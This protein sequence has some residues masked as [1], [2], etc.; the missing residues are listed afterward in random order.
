MDP[1][2]TI[3]RVHQCSKCPGDTSYKCESCHCDLCPQCK[4]SHEKDLKTIDH[5]VST[6]KEYINMRIQTV[7]IAKRQQHIRTIH[8]IKSEA[9][10][11]RPVLLSEIKSD[12]NTFQKKIPHGQSD[13]LSKA[14][15]LNHL[16]DNVLYDLLDNA[17]CD[18]NFKHR[19]LK[20]EIK[21]YKHISQLQ[22]YV[23]IYEQWAI[24]PLQFLSFIKK[25]LPQI[26]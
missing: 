25:A 17:F 3:C 14:R 9:L 23:H 24:R 22:N 10:F 26:T 8:T 13:M 21:M 12:I 16:V 15:K 6:K 4:E 19:C 1:A 11:Y 2:S 18:F 5:N 20:Q 7:Y